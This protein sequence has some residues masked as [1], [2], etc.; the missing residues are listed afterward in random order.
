MNNDLIYAALSTDGILMYAERKADLAL[1]IFDYAT[2]IRVS[3]HEAA[4]G[5]TWYS[6]PAG[7]E[8]DHWEGDGDAEQWEQ[9]NA[10]GPREISAKIITTV[11]RVIE[12]SQI[13][14]TR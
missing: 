13:G 7:T 14:V 1:A 10:A 9:W 6:L 2:Q 12:A 4:A 3:P 11:L 8:I 5:V